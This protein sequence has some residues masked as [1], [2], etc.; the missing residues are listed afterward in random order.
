MS[1]KGFIPKVK[2]LEQIKIELDEND[3]K[4]IKVNSKKKFNPTG[5]PMKLG[6]VK[7]SDDEEETNKGAFVPHMFVNKNTGGQVTLHGKPVR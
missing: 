2:Q 7:G 4:E 1:A 3:E 6:M 5:K